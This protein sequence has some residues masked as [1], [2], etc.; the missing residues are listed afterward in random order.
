MLEWHYVKSGVQAGPV[1]FEELSRM[2]AA[3]ELARADTVW[4]PGMTTWTQAGAVA[5]LFAEPAVHLEYAGFGVRL[6][7]RAIDYV[8]IVMIGIG[9]GIVGGV[10]LGVLQ[11][12][13][14]IDAGWIEK[15]RAQSL[16]SVVLTLGGLVV[17]HGLSEGLAGASPGKFALGLR[18]IGA[19][20]AP[21]G[22]GA[23]MIRSAA[24][25]LDSFFFGAVGYSKMSKTPERQRYGDA[26]AGTVVVK[27]V[28]APESARRSGAA[29]AGGWF[30]GAFGAGALNVAGLMLKVFG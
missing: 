24:F 22:V 28:G 3:G 8:C 25:L 21:C 4:K 5:G 11:G 2:A 1:T 15:I 18:V 17:F 23:A 27:A 12:M 10:I 6:A 26:W 29:L 13:G 20:G 9:G 7:A 16:G 30:L 19:D 14:R